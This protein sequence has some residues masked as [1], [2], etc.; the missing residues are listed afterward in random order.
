MKKILFLSIFLCFFGLISFA[1]YIVKPT[2]SSS[3]TDTT[4]V[5][6]P[7]KTSE[8]LPATK[9][10]AAEKYLED[11]END[12]DEFDE[13]ELDE[14][15]ASIA[16]AKATLGLKN[17]STTSSKSVPNKNKEVFSKIEESK[18]VI[19]A[20]TT[21]YEAPSLMLNGRVASDGKPKSDF[22]QTI[23]TEEEKKFYNVGG[24]KVTEIDEIDRDSIYISPTILPSFVGGVE[25]MK[26]FFAQNLKVPE[27]LKGQEIKG[28]VFVR[29]VVRKDGKIDKVH[30][31][32]GPNDD[33]NSEAIRVIKMMPAWQ[34]ASDKGDAVSSY[35]V[36]PISFATASAV[37]K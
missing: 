24:L 21:T 18:P 37:K 30:L 28:R 10:S 23:L 31:V 9:K 17:V 13:K 8:I 25:A 11:D 27:V 36:L 35:H 34:P 22:K 33:C 12:E 15:E 2:V 3:K 26:S 1:Q 5:S 20:P 32:K 19:A 14:L 16:K 29:F 4:T 6:P 7:K